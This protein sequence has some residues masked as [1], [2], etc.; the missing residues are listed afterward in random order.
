VATPTWNERLRKYVVEEF[1]DVAYSTGGVGLASKTLSVVE[2]AEVLK[3]THYG[4]VLAGYVS[5]KG[6]S[7]AEAGTIPNGVTVKVQKLDGT[8]LDDG[9]TINVKLLLGGS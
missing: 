4:T 1:N 9:A 5:A 2:E 7:A 3:V 6:L 8:E